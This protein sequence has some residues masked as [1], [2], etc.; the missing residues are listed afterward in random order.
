MFDYCQ[1]T[2]SFEKKIVEQMDDQHF[3][4]IYRR[5]LNPIKNIFT[6]GR[7]MKCYK[8]RKKHERLTVLSVLNHDFILRKRAFGKR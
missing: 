2:R 3:A 7:L 5:V 8:I 6:I 1:R 4:E